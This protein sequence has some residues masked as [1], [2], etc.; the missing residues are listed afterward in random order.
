MQYLSS[1]EQVCNHFTEQ[2]TLQ[3]NHEK[4]YE[5]SEQTTEDIGKFL[6]KIHVEENYKK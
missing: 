1:D 2:S 5:D 4:L 3:L 6:S